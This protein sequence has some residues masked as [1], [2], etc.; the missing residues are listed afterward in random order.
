MEDQLQR[1]TNAI[2]DGKAEEARQST[3]AAL[4]KG[5]TTNEILDGM[6]EAVNI[7]VDLHEVGEYDQDRV[8]AAEAAVN[9]SLQVIE[10]RLAK[11]ESKFNVRATVGPVGLKAGNLLALALSAALRS[12]GLRALSLGKTQTP[13]E[14][15]RN[16]EELRADLVLPLLSSDG[17][18][19]Q[20]DAFTEAI[21]RGGFKS[22][23]K[24]IA[25]APG[26]PDTL[27]PT[28]SVAR[29]SGEAISRATEWALKRTHARRG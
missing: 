24:V 3:Y 10:D 9:S 27:Q 17:V 2:L 13:L 21:E 1:L 25:L 20:L 28:L 11:A 23:F 15:L 6:L 4:A 18:E 5:S 16:S 14:I 26:L 8:N 29:N 12:V 7:V 19:R 22:K